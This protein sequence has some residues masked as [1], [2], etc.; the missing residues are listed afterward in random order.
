MKAEDL[1][2]V[3]IV[4]HDLEATQTQLSSLL[5]YEWGPEI[6]A[7][8]EV[9]LPSGLVTVEVRCAFS[10]TTPRLE[11]VRSVPGTFWEP[12][13]G[14]GVHH[15][16][17]WS[18]DVDADAAELVSQGYVTEATRSGPDGSLFF[19][20]LRSDTGYRMELVTRAAEPHIQQCWAHH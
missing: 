9:T 3:G 2:H 18:D 15:V 8:L 10:I 14:S 13:E 12:A 17:Y 6:G 4:T 19:A 20:F 5:G 16:G 1:F 7:P 11:V